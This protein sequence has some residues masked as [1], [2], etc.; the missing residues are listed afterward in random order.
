MIK[1]VS[2]GG[3]D[4]FSLRDLLFIPTN[5]RNSISLDEMLQEVGVRRN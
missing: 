3:V 5:G 1:V 4:Y 2:I